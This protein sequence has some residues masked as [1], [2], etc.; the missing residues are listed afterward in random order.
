MFG[1]AGEKTQLITYWLWLWFR[2]H[3]RAR[4]NTAPKVINLNGGSRDLISCIR[5]CP[6]S[7]ENSSYHAKQLNRDRVSSAAVESKQRGTDDVY[8]TGSVWPMDGQR[9]NWRHAVRLGVQPKEKWKAHTCAD[10]NCSP[11]RWD[12]SGWILCTSL[13][14]EKKHHFQACC[15]NILQEEQSS[16]WFIFNE[17]IL[18]EIKPLDFYRYYNLLGF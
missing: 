10:Q 11:W 12:S 8:H 7:P 18:N 15:W 5:T 16:M 14:R 4:E 9:N 17:P 6:R 3:P 2:S 1:F 13:Q